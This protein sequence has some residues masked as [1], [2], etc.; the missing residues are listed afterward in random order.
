MTASR[1]GPDGDWKFEYQYRYKTGMFR[2]APAAC[3]FDTRGGLH[4]IDRI[5]EG[6]YVLVETETPGGYETAEPVLV[7]VKKE[8]QVFRYYMENRRRKWYAD[9]TD[10]NGRQI[11]GARLALYRADENGGFSAEEELLEDTWMSG[12][13]GTYY[14]AEL[15][16]PDHFSA[17]EPQ[18]IEIG[19]D[20]GG[21][22]RAVNRLSRGR[23]EILKLDAQWHEKPLP[24]A[25]FEVKNVKTGELFRMVTGSDGKAVSRE[26]P[27]AYL[28]DD[29][30]AVPYE[31]Q[32][33]EIQAP[34]GF[35]LDQRVWKFWFGN[36]HTPVAVQKI[37]A[38]N[39]ETRLWFSKSSFHTDHFVKGAR[40]PFIMQR[41]KMEKCSP[42]ES[43]WKHGSPVRS[44]TW[45]REKYPEEE[46]TSLWRRKHQRDIPQRIR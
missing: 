26:L 12:V 13:E 22:I 9:K 38:E 5:P 20:S 4:R 46:R 35:C 43:H 8:S 29:G 19:K 41:Q 40:L 10:E 39:E 44:P 25:W 30:R 16:T 37:K 45:Y 34:E 14:L 33:R 2:D 42:G 15:R 1:T 24:G 17:M 7:Q 3:S 27:A 21:I 36:D 6:Y 23:I 11:R 32:V 18:K 31:Y 28:G